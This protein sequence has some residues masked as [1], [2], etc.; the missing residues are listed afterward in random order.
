MKLDRRLSLPG[1]GEHAWVMTSLKQKI[2]LWGGVSHNLSHGAHYSWN[3]R[4]KTPGILKLSSRALE[5]SW[6]KTDDFSKLPENTWNF[7]ENF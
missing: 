1:C 4:L 5:N 7:V 3:S 6:K 2:N